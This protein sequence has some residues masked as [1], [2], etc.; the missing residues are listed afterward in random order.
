MDSFISH[1]SALRWWQPPAPHQR[2][3]R[4]PQRP[5]TST[6]ERLLVRSR[7]S[8]AFDPVA[9]ARL[10]LSLD[11]LHVMLFSPSWRTRDESVVQHVWLGP[12]PERPFI[13]V[14]PGVYV[15]SP[16]LC[17]V[18]MAASLPMPR[19]VELGYEMCG[20]Y[21]RSF[22]NRSS[23]F[24]RRPITSVA[25]LADAVA[26]LDGTHGIKAARRALSLISDGARSPFE[27][28]VAMLLSM[29]R[30]LGGFA[31][32]VPRMNRRVDLDAEARAVAKRAFLSCDLFWPRQRVDVE[33]DSRVWHSD[34]EK[35]AEDADRRTAL[36]LMGVDMV[37]ITTSQLFRAEAFRASAGLVA[38][39]LGR[40]ESRCKEGP[41]ERFGE[42]HGLLLQP[43]L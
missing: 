32:E 40:R 9:V 5:R 39:K 23:Y 7:L 34:A 18:Q 4:F 42:L 41:G 36:D 30:S 20:G 22:E 2:V 37:T 6:A 24:E 35:L 29:P 17:F 11:P 19:L 10:G 12:L 43:W 8:G 3:G 14:A 38:R 31:L 33:Y 13:A 1:E 15:A 27:A 25:R 16:E 21:A 26:R 28:I